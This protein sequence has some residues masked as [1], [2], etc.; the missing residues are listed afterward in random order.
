MF[1]WDSN[2]YLKFE[3]ERTRPAKDLLNRVSINNPIKILDIGCGPGN[4]TILLKEKFKDSFVLGID[5]SLNMIDKARETY[6][7]LSWKCI[8]AT[9]ELDTLD[10]D[11][12]IIFSNACIQWIPDHRKLILEM[13]SLLNKDGILAIQI[14]NNYNEEIHKLI[15]EVSSS[16][17]WRDLIKVNRDKYVLE[18][19]D[20]FDILTENS[21]DFE[22][23]ETVYYHNLK[24]HEDILEWYRGTG[25]RPYLD[26]LDEKEKH[27]F[28]EDILKEIKN[29]YKEQVDG[30]IIFKFP[31]LFFIAKA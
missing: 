26:Q 1:S 7:D 21:K 13:L 30:N 27:I 25:L 16:E 9:K 4:S 18:P 17:K 19:G 24:S 14:P 29:R 22:I 11:Y 8:D 5:S 3:N 12:D 10:N 31:R 2:V 28:E 6:P 20:Y 15:I 23:W